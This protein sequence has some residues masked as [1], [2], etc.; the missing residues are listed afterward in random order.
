MVALA[1]GF[2]TATKDSNQLS[3]GGYVAERPELSHISFIEFPHPDV[4]RGE[5]SEM[6]P[7]PAVSG[8]LP[9]QR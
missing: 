4:G 1:S 8:W 7:I 2:P 9:A 5:K 6:S 3:C